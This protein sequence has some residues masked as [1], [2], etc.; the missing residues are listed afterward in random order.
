M[1]FFNFFKDLKDE[2]NDVVTTLDQDTLELAVKLPECYQTIK[3]EEVF[4]YLRLIII[5][6]INIS[7]F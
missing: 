4:C 1:H 7:N 6:S 2:Y 3:E 5:L